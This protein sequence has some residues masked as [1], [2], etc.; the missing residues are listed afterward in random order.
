[1]TTALIFAALVAF[2]LAAARSEPNLEKRSDLALRNADTAIGSARDAYRAGETDKAKAAFDEVRESLDLSWD[3]LVESKKNPRS[4]GG[5]K[6]AEMAT[7]QIARK[8]DDLKQTMS[9]LD[10]EL[11]DPIRA[12]ASEIHDRLLTAIMAKKKR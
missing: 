4:S 11:I 7:R 6:R 12:H 3:S 9:A 8:L 2:D 5:Y 10:H 1:M